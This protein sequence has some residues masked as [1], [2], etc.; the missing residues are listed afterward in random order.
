MRFILLAIPAY[1]I[2]LGITAGII[3]NKAIRF[4]HKSLK[5][6]KIFIA[7]VLIALL[8]IAFQPLLPKADNQ[9]KNEVPSF[10]DTWYT[11]LNNIKQKP[12]KCLHKYG[13]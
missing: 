2:G 7:I 13:K 5:L 9:A 11:A 4:S 6:N 1:S 3:Y 10:D 12:S 8:I